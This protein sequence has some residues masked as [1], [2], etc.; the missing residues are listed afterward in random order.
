LTAY[1]L[2]ELLQTLDS[3]AAAVSA[4]VFFS[5]TT[6]FSETVAMTYDS[7][8]QQYRGTLDLPIDAPAGRYEVHVRATCPGYSSDE[9]QSAFWVAPPLEVGIDLNTDT[10]RPHETLAVTVAVQDRG[11]L[12]SGAG[13]WADIVMPGS[14]VRIPLLPTGEGDYV[15][16]F[17]PA[18][19]SSALGG[20]WAIEATADYKGSS[21]TAAASVLVLR[22]IYL[23]L[24]LRNH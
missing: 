14:R 16:A 9:S 2:D 13:V 11:E 17:R 3:P 21:A 10:I 20:V 15:A 12:V 1:V 23:P 22:E 18:D 8:L 7:A 19:L 5:P 24:I 6:E 4:S